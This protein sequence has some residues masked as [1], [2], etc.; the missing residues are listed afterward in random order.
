MNSRRSLRALRLDV[1]VVEMTVLLLLTAGCGSDSR[2][3]TPAPVS[4]PAPVDRKTLRPVLLPDLSKVEASAEKQLR[5]GDAALRA[6]VGNPSISDGDLGFAYGEMGKLLMAAEYRDAAEPAFLNAQALTPNDPRWPYYLGHLYKLRGDSAR[7]AASF[8]HA[9]QLR[10]DDLPT[11]VWLGNE[12]LNQGRT[13]DAEPL[14]MRASAIQSQSVAVLFGL[15]RTA[16][17]KQEYVR[18]VDYLQ[19]ALSLDPKAVVIHYPLAM[20]YRGM[21]DTA[22]AEMHLRARGPGE[23]RPPDPLMHELDSILES[24]VSYEV[25]G[26]AALDEG[27]WE[28]AAEAFRKGIALAPEEPSLRH[29]LGTS[30]AMLGDVQG[31]ARQFE[32][33]TRRW[34]KFAKAQYSL[35]VLLAASGRPRESIDHLSAAVKDD[36]TYSEARLQLAEGLRMSGRVAD[37]LPHY[38][39]AI[40]LNPGLPEARLGYA[41]ALAALQ[42]VDEART[43]LSEGARI[44][45]DRREFAEALS[46]LPPG[47]TSR[48]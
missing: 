21:G 43:Q 35:G 32:E 19:R 10:P 18:A 26:A 16:L 15:G 13:A 48:R 33:V 3:A 4:P 47:G 22:Q 1:A 45:P 2:P 6:K 12:Y 14:F 23:V 11:L 9:L 31:A 44:Y 34:P 7:T 25:R 24:A 37:S 28:G 42:R 46:H 41:M 8:E 20:A 38:E 5:D 39:E 29:K 17:A 40:R 30:L 36:P 27:N